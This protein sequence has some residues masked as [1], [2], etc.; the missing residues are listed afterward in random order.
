MKSATI[1][2][3]GLIG[4]SI[5]KALVATGWDV[6]FVDPRV[7]LDDAQ[8]AAAATKKFDSIEEVPV[9]GIIILATPVD[10]ALRLIKSFREKSDVVVSVC[11]VMAPLRDAATA[12]G[13]KFIATHPFAGS[14]QSGL[15]AA[16]ATLFAKKR[17]FVDDQSSN[18]EVDALIEACAAELV[19]V[20]CEEHDR[21]VAFTSHLPQM[22]STA[23][24]SVIASNGID[25][26]LFA[27]SGLRSMLRLAA[28]ERAVWKPI[29]ETNAVSIEEAATDLIE[30]IEAMLRGGEAEPF[31]RAN[32]VAKAL[33]PQSGVQSPE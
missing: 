28:S 27:G 18:A 20:D 25:L 10:A 12:N 13:T 7:K 21:A 33:S 32:D 24:A 6:G 19:R 22:L 8:A 26:E 15:E 31:A 4:G 30:T 9:G 3:L 1:L 11:S 23:L 29:F 14:E 5:G 2:G 17:W 16:S